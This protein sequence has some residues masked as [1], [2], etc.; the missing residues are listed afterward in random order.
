MKDE[1]LH[2]VWP[3]AEEALWPARFSAGLLGIFALLAVVLCAIGIYGVVGY[4]VGQRVRE[5]GIRLALGA[6]PGGVVLTVLRQSAVTLGIGLAFGLAGSYL[7][8]W[9]LGTRLT[10]LL[11]GVKTTSPVPFVATALLLALVGL[12]AS[13]IPAR[14]AAKVDPIVAL[15]YE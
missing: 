8:V 10:D 11:V 9:W 1:Q 13:Y 14:R 7:L 6:Q 2:S 5:F 4:T 3:E 15:H 12:L